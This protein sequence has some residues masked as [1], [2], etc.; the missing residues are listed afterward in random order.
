MRRDLVGDAAVVQPNHPARSRADK[1]GDRMGGDCVLEV[2][3]EQRKS[4]HARI[5]PTRPIAATVCEEI[6]CRRPAIAS[7]H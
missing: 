6:G 1:C 2:A 7:R 3:G 4:E 5:R